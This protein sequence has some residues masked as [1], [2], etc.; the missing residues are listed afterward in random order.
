MSLAD[1][2][3]TQLE[4]MIMLQTGYKSDSKEMRV[5]ELSIAVKSTSWS[6][7]MFFPGMSSEED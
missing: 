5:G 7:Y 6:H 2:Q 4:E 1:D 3:V